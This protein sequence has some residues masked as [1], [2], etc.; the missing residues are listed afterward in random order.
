VSAIIRRGVSVIM[1]S[2]RFHSIAIAEFF[3]HCPK[4]ISWNI[5]KPFK[6]IA[7]SSFSYTS[8]LLLGNALGGT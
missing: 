1:I 5:D 4:E 3:Q 2:H 7:S 8:I 6:S